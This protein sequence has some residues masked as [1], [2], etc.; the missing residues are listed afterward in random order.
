MRGMRVRCRVVFVSV[1]THSRRRAALGQLIRRPNLALLY[2][3]YIQ[4]HYTIT[5]NRTQNFSC[6][7][8]SALSMRPT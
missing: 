4:S 5:K 7:K 3:L 2:R 6:P 1:S 8:S